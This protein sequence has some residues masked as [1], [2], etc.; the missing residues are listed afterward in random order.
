MVAGGAAHQQSTIMPHVK[1]TPL[2]C[3]VPKK[4]KTK[5]SRFFFLHFVLS[6]QMLSSALGSSAGLG[7]SSA[8]DADW[9]V[10]LNRGGWGP[11]ERVRKPLTPECVSR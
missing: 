1:Q 11:R 5:P 7:W 3:P 10:N 2:Q 8:H 9:M 6:K 4:G